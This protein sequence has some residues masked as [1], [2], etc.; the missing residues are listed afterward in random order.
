MAHCPDCSTPGAYVGFN[1]IECLNPHCVHFKIKQEEVCPCCGKAGH[2]P[3][4]GFSPK[5]SAKAPLAPPK[6][7]PPSNT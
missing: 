7:K 4:P 6:T 1:S 2:V 5:T 3:G